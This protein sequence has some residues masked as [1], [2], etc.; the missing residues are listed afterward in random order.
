MATDAPLLYVADLSAAYGG[1]HVLHAVSFELF[2]REFVAILGPN[3]AGK[4]TLLKAIMRLIPSQG[5]VKVNGESIAGKRPEE[6]ASLG[7]AY[8]PEGR[9]IFGPMTVQ[10]NL[11]LGAYSKRRRGATSERDGELE[12]VFSIFPRLRE[13]SSQA[14][15]SLSGGEQQMLA[16]GRALMSAP[17]LL[18][19]DEPSLGL[20][21]RLAAEVFEALSSLNGDGLSILVVEQKAPLALKLATRAHMLRGGRLVSSVTPNDPASRQQLADIYLGG[22]LR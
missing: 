22:A 15:G 10:E 21:P 4:S 8:V 18:I 6:L 9:G 11:D 5:D 17:R 13:R 20:A 1:V 12:R 3:G 2:P 7:V 14:A 19:L 16:I